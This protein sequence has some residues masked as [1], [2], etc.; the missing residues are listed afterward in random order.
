[1]ALITVGDNLPQGLE[2]I[3]LDGTGKQK[4]RQ[5][6]D[7][8]GSGRG[9]EVVP[10]AQG[11]VITGLSDGR[12]LV[13]GTDEAGKLKWVR[14]LAQTHQNVGVG[15]T[16]IG[17][18][19]VIVVGSVR[20][21]GDALSDIYVAKLDPSG[22]VLWDKVLGLPDDETAAG[23]VGAVDGRAG[24]ICATRTPAD[25]RAGGDDILL[26]GV[27]S[28]GALLW[29][30]VA[31]MAEFAERA[32]AIAR[33]A[34][35]TYFV[36]AHSLGPSSSGMYFAEF[37]VLG[38]PKWEKRVRGIY[39]DCLYSGWSMSM[40]ADGIATIL[41]VIGDCAEFPSNIGGYGVLR[42]E[43]G[44]RM[45]WTIERAVVET[46]RYLEQ[47]AAVSP[48]EFIFSR[49]EETADGTEEG[50]VMAVRFEIPDGGE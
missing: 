40:G 22:N 7:L 42:I 12:V 1:M 11:F 13:L 31:G 37:D 28:D 27:D 39:E 4:W 23:V 5:S 20:A 19:E 44:G 3:A 46:D 43:P 26:A 8:D 34:A 25:P 24:V 35:N 38:R 50:R 29:T 10:V 6:Y 33:G 15:A 30:R 45:E 48:R 47:V 36:M 16:S 9:C 18:Q 21:H 32:V 14:K 2:L 17:A 49:I 41:A